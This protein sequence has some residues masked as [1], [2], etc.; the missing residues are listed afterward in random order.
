VIER[1]EDWT[2]GMQLTVKSQMQHQHQS[3]VRDENHQLHHNTERYQTIY[4][5]SGRMATKEMF[6][7][8]KPTF[9]AYRHETYS[10]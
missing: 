8:S 3:A 7:N 6:V 5:T 2:A 1:D 10:F 4:R 9:T